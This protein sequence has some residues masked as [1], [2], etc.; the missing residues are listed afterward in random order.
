MEWLRIFVS[1]LLGLFH[2]RELEGDLDTEIRCHVEMLPEE[3]M[4]RG[5]SREE[6]RYAARREFGGVEQTKESCD[7]LRLVNE[8][9]SQPTPTLTSGF[10]NR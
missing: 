9:A 8:A 5:M 7:I 2:K 6:A 1:R 4:R 3:N 10:V